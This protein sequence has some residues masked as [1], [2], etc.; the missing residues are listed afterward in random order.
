MMR[1]LLFVL[2]LI[3]ASSAAKDENVAPWLTLNGKA[4]TVVG[5]EGFSGQFPEDTDLALAPIS[6]DG[7][8]MLCSVQLT[9]DGE[10]I[11]QPNVDIS[12]STNVQE[13]HPNKTK[14]YNVNG[15]NVTGYFTIDYTIVELVEKITGVQS[16]WTRSDG[17]DGYSIAPF[18]RGNEGEF[19]VSNLWINVPYAQFYSENKMNMEDYIRQVP[20]T[21]NHCLSSPEIGFLKA[22]S[23]R[24]VKNLKLYFAFHDKDEVEPTTQKTYGSIASDLAA[25]KPMVAGIVVP[26]EYI[27]PVDDSNYLVAKPTTLVT[28][29]HKLGL[30]VYVSGFANDNVL[31]YNYSYEPTAEYLNFISNGKFSVDGLITDFPPTAT[32]AIMCFAP[33]NDNR[34]KGGQPLIITRGGASGIYADS[35]DLAYQ[36][37]VD[38]EADVID[39]SVQMSQDGVAFCM[40]TPDL[41]T[42]TNAAAIFMDRSSD[43]KEIQIDSG[44]FSFDLTWEEIQTLQ[45][46]LTS[47]FEKFIGLYR[48]PAFKNKGK[49]VT[50]AQFLEF[51]RSKAVTGIMI[52]LDNVPYLASKGLD[53]ITTVTTALAK[54]QYDKKASPQV[55]VQSDDTSVLDKFKNVP[56]Y[57][58]ILNIKEDISSVPKAA[59][60]EIKKHADGVTLTRYSIIATDML[61]FT[62]GKRKTVETLQGLN[63]T[64]YVSS[65]A[66]E[67]VSLA[68]DYYADPVIE[69]ATY[70][71]TIGV[72]GFITEFPKTASRYQRS[73]C[74]DVND[75]KRNYTI[76]PIEPGALVNFTSRP[77]PKAADPPTPALTLQEVVDPPLPKVAKP[78]SPPK[79]TQEAPAPSS[80]APAGLHSTAAAV[81]AAVAVALLSLLLTA[82]YN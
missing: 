53:I 1:G 32:D 71:H 20:L 11:C 34:T 17:F 3:H 65:L 31:P 36:Q 78:Q 10:A 54:N 66:N 43:V 29:A 64:V 27:W 18:K 42:S 49:F 80:S 76:L 75:L 30:E 48:N 26:K 28:D 40:L 63:L 61:G 81:A 12:K 74:S 82:G 46:Q 2:L 38:D 4:P 14:T 21:E 15:K 41:S 52:N 44:I 60:E 56:S 19:M 24:K 68:F 77:P 69:I 6:Y 62:T 67:Y 25:L 57:K 55:L 9:M 73:A 79:P 16:T 39:C 37:A 58:R 33:F 50:L 51:A 22:I 59:A 72:N 45:P 35:T 47:P 5:R 8:L 13:I 70:T 23:G 7:M